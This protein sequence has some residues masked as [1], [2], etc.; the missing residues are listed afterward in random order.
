[1]SETKAA[2]EIEKSS[3]R[4]DLLLRAASAALLV[5]ATFFVTGITIYANNGDGF[6]FQFADVI[7]CLGI[8]TSI[9]FCF[10][11]VFQFPFVNT[12]YSRLTNCLIFCIGIFLYFQSNWFLWNLGPLMNGE[13]WWDWDLHGRITVIEAVLYVLL[14]LILCIFYKK[15]YNN[16]LKLSLALIAIQLI[17]CIPFFFNRQIDCSYKRYIINED[18]K[19]EFAKDHNFIICV[20]DCF[21]IPLMNEVFV[22]EPESKG[23]FKDFTMYS[24]M[25]SS[26]ATTQ[27]TVPSILTGVDNLTGDKKLLEK[28]YHDP[29]KSILLKLSNQHFRN[30]IYAFSTWTD[31]K[32]AIFFDKSYIHNIREKTNKDKIS[33]I[34]SWRDFVNC[35]ALRISPLRIK[36]R[37]SKILCNIYD[38]IVASIFSNADLVNSDRK[39]ENLDFY[40]QLKEKTTVGASDRVFK[41]IHLRGVHTPFDIDENINASDFSRPDEMYVPCGIGCAKIMKEIIDQLKKLNLYDNSLIIFMGDHGRYD[42]MF[43]NYTDFPS[44]HNPLFMIKMPLKIQN[45]L[46]VKDNIVFESDIC[47]I[48]LWKDAN[49]TV[50][51]KLG[52]DLSPEQKSERERIWNDCKSCLPAWNYQKAKF[53]LTDKKYDCSKPIFRFLKNPS[54]ENNCCIG[55]LQ[56]EPWSTLVS[57]KFDIV[58]ISKDNCYSST[59]DMTQN[60]VHFSCDMSEVCD[61]NYCLYYALRN[62]NGYEM[63]PFVHCT[64]S[65]IDGKASIEYVISQ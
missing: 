46:C 27:T 29:E 31:V 21:S 59:F 64:I 14:F 41:Y 35:I 44:G 60:R 11:F 30:E 58:L 56:L 23:W 50:D 33:H 25:Y 7:S 16:I 6:T 53:E 61:G 24:R 38:R 36:N 55:R 52:E 65:V 48:P 39:T 9:I 19:F 1:M 22:Q 45:E 43:G 18:S 54:I 40:N 26:G 20:F 57:N 28:Q 37:T 42:N 63:H 49:S 17:T 10:L 4:F 32:Q 15:I 47:E 62:K 8:V 13:F 5:A 12:F 2:N 51:W 34:S 3:N